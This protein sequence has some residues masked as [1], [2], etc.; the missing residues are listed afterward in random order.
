MSGSFAFDHLLVLE[1]LVLPDE[2]AD[3]KA[4]RGDFMHILVAP[5]RYARDAKDKACATFKNAVPQRHDR[6]H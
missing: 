5:L 2:A 4:S 3:P 6:T 1:P